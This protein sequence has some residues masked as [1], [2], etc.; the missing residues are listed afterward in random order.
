MLRGHSGLFSGQLHLK[1]HHNCS[2][3]AQ[4]HNVNSRRN[5]CKASLLFEV[6]A[7]ESE[8][9]SG[10]G[11]GRG[12]LLTRFHGS[13]R[14]SLVVVQDRRR[15]VPHSKNFPINELKLAQTYKVLIN[16]ATVFL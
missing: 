3:S 1:G 5:S 4:T 12:A 6:G 14:S 16:L 2:T 13:L 15:H 8:G 11:G 7:E 9:S 10:A